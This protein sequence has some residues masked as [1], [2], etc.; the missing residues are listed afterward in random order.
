MGVSK[1]DWSGSFIDLPAWT[2]PACQQ[3]RYRVVPKTKV[4]VETG[5]SLRN[6]RHLDWDPTWHRDRFTW[7]MRCDN[8]ACGEVATVCGESADTEFYEDPELGSVLGPKHTVVFIH[9]APFPFPIGAK[10]PEDVRLL[11]QAAATLIWINP[12]GSANKLRQAT[13]KLLLKQKVKAFT[14]DKNRKRKAITLHD[15]LVDFKINHNKAKEA[16]ILLAVKW[17]GN[18]GSHIGGITLEDVLGGFEMFEHV[19]D[20]LYVGSSEKIIATARRINSRK[21]PAKRG[22]K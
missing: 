12:E 20:S 14:I 17:L 15:R 7:I 11:I 10:I 13:E 16:D 3:G 21:G 22:R 9:P 1:S 5:D 6:H 2:C 8:P 18:A 4:Y 19:L